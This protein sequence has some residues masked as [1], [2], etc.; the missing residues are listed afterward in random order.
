MGQ[1]LAA[2]P[3]AAAISD[4]EAEAFFAAAFV[5]RYSVSSESNLIWR[6]FGVHTSH[7]GEKARRRAAIMVLR[8]WKDP[9]VRERLLWL[10]PNMSFNQFPDVATHPDVWTDEYFQDAYALDMNIIWLVRVRRALGM[11]ESLSEWLQSLDEF[12]ERRY[13]FYLNV[14]RC[15]LR[16]IVYHD[17]A[18][19][20]RQAETAVAAQATLT[21]ELREKDRL[22]GVLRR[23]VRSLEQ[24]RKRLREQARRAELKARAVLTEARGEVAAARRVLTE[25]QAAQE[26]ELAEQARRFE[27]ELSRLRAQAAAA[28]ADF[29]HSLSDLAAH[30]HDVL[31][32]RA[33]TVVGRE[34]DREVHRLQVESLGGILALEGG[35]VVLSAESGFA[36][37]E[38]S[39]RS[40]AFE[41]VLVKCDGLHRRKD[42]R[43]GIAMSGFQVHMGNETVWRQSR[44][45]CCGPTS[46]SLMAEY[47][48]VTMAMS[49]L[50]AA[51]ADSGAKLEIWSDCRALVN[52][53]HRRQPARRKLGC[54]TLDKTVRR[55]MQQLRKQG[56]EVHLRW[57]PRVEVHAVDR[58]C[59][60]AY[61][62]LAWYHRSA[63][64]PRAS[65]KSF[66]RAAVG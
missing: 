26:R 9:K 47:G 49:W 15:M 12:A 14:A 24:D 59:A 34:A 18:L 48:A 57:V 36:A 33:V 1:W 60:H 37:L 29:V 32:G 55:L 2:D 52:R 41:R 58:L 20:E 62:N 10:V 40:L 21:Q 53:L 35:D 19:E 38:R 65:L 3:A 6:A 54:I 61:Y 27:A 51:G 28:R 11:A 31:S 50:L 7:S 64:Q 45:V 66:L 17:P 22:S 43:P 30:R 16:R 39:L 4:D 5:V 13:R 63:K 46:G 23:D 42:G 8:K 44:V 56:C 25:R